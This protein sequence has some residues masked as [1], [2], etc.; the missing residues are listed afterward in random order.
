MAGEKRKRKSRD[1]QQ[2]ATQAF[3]QY[4]SEHDGTA[5]NAEID[6]KTYAKVE[7]G[8]VY[9]IVLGPPPEEPRPIGY[10]VTVWGPSGQ[11]YKREFDVDGSLSCE[12]FGAA[13]DE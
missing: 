12:W 13:C 5:F 9:P 3:Y 2:T 1:R 7:A 6:G 10:F 4:A 8:A 11:W